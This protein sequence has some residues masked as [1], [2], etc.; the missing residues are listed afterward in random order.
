MHGE[1]F[2]PLQFPV[3]PLFPTPGLPVHLPLFCESSFLCLLC[4]LNWS[5]ID[6]LKAE[7]TVVYSYM[8]NSSLYNFQ[9]KYFKNCA[10]IH[11]KFTFLTLLTVQFRGI[12]CHHSAAQTS[13][14]CI[15]RTPSSCKTGNLYSL[16]ITLRILFSQP[17]TATFLLS[18]SV[19]STSLHTSLL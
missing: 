8:Y 3:L 6:A 11:I 16:E 14:L 18:V 5:F 12:P 7:R 13:S 19:N 15:S 4:F 1:Q 9:K 2:A 10:K 17:L